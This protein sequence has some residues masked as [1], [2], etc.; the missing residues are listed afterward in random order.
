MHFLQIIAVK[1]SYF[2]KAFIFWKISKFMYREFRSIV[3]LK[4]ESRLTTARIAKVMK[5]L[6]ASCYQ[7]SLYETH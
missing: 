4:R 2:T 5:S 3:Q 1:Q 6:P 7:F